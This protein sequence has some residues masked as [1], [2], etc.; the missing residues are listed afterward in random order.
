MNK[1]LAAGIEASRVSFA[2]KSKVPMP[3][4]ASASRML[5]TSSWTL[6]AAGLAFFGL[7]LR[8]S[9]MTPL[10]PVEPLLDPWAEV[11]ALVA[12]VLLVVIGVA[13]QQWAL[14]RQRETAE[15]AQGQLGESEERY[16]QL[17]DVIPDGSS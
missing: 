5:S 15:V 14:R 8:G 12:V 13:A 6:A 7:W 10:T 17:F 2:L 9:G 16:R 11:R 3:R 1:P 4:G